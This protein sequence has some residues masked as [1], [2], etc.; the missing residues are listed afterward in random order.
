M[1]LRSI[2]WILLLVLSYIFVIVC[3]V[4]GDVDRVGTVGMLIF[5]TVCLLRHCLGIIYI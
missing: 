4:R 2:E 5:V 1:G 3:L